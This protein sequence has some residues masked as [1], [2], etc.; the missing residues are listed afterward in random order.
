MCGF[1]EV[2]DLSEARVKG[3]VSCLVRVPGTKFVSPGRAVHVL[4]HRAISVKTE[5]QF[6][7]C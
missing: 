3:S 6:F 1:L 5:P 2:P 7:Y 4:N